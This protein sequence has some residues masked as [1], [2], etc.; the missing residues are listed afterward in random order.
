MVRMILGSILLCYFCLQLAIS[1]SIAVGALPPDPKIT[2]MGW[3]LMH[4]TLFGIP[5]LSLVMWGRRGR[6]LRKLRVQ[7]TSNALN[8]SRDQLF[9]DHASREATVSKKTEGK[10]NHDEQRSQ[11]QY[12]PSSDAISEVRL[13]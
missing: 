13:N 12:R 5:G 6:R 10:V 9:T 7:A 8:I 1:L 11:S 4:L 3:F 2:P